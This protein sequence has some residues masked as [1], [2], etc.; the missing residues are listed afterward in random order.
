M[1]EP[2][3]LRAARTED[4]AAVRQLLADAKLPLEGLDEQFGERYAVASAQGQ[5]IAAEG[6]EVYDRWGLLR[7][8]VVAPAHRGAGLGIRL[9]EERVGWARR[10]QLEALYLL[11]TTAAPFFARL[12]FVKVPRASAP[13][14]VQA[15]REFAT[16]CPASATCM[17]LGLDAP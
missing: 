4:L 7:S 3:V 15:S 8:A 2:V 11:T 12:G 9:S 13:A 5:I 16:A 6:V 10:Q 14:A 1:A 17:R